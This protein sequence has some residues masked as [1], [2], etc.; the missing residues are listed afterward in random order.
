MNKTYKSLIAAAVAALVQVSAQAQ[1]TVVSELESFNL[2]SGSYLNGSGASVEA[3]FTSGNVTFPSLYQTSYGG[4]WSNGWA[5]STVTNDTTAGSGNMYAS[6]AGSGHNSAKYAVGQN[7]SILHATGAD[8]GKPV[9]GVYITNGTFAAKSMENGDAYAKKFGGTTGNDPD[10]FVVT[11]QAYANGALKTD[12][13]NFYLA[14]FRFA[15][16]ANDY[17]IKAW[18][19]V[20][21]TSLGNAD[22]LLF[23]LSSSDAGQFGMNTPAFFCVDDVI[24][25]TDTADFENLTLGANTF[26]NKRNTRVSKRYADVNIEYPSSYSVSSYGDF[27]S[28]GFAISNVTDTTTAGYGNMYS[29]FAGEG[30][31]GSETYAVAQN[32]AM[33]HIR[34]SIVPENASIVK[35]VFVTNSTYTALSMRNGDSFAKKFGGVSGNDEDWF[36]VSFIGY[37]A[38]TPKNDTV[39][40]Y[41]ADFRSADNS[42]DYI[43]KDWTWVDLA[44]LGR[45]DSVKMILSSSDMG[46][47]GMNTPAY[48]CL[49]NFTTNDIAT[50]VTEVMQGSNAIGIYPNPAIDRITVDV[51]ADAAVR[52]ADLSGRVVVSERISASDRTL[53]VAS[54]PAGAY[55]VVV[56]T[57]G[58]VYTKKLIRQ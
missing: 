3:A 6:F 45:C 28:S 31:E 26:W 16:N 58:I 29:S 51:A 41:L 20:D 4:Y 52:I 30:A 7:G 39:H 8:S 48:L 50:G 54:L 22:S 27:W 9:K 15:D 37:S 18:S 21:L 25:D 43:I 40:F 34:Q 17:I 46:Q 10:F 44:V 19:W 5:Y 47:F 55:I 33:L 24:T 49:D 56:E 1:T 14:D 32:N 53:S 2:W 23:R 12:S 35:G 36:R 38:G 11:I 42:K 57:E 13:V